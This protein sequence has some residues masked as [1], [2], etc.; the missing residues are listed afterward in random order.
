MNF[1]RNVKRLKQEKGLRND[2]FAALTGI[3]KGTLD[4]L[5]SGAITEPKLSTAI[6]MAEALS[7][8]LDEL[9]DFSAGSECL[10]REEA[11]LLESFRS[12]DRYGR[13][14]VLSLCRREAERTRSENEFSL[15]TEKGTQGDA[16]GKILLPLF[17]LPVSAG[18][19]TI[20]DGD[21]SET[22][23]VRNTR[24]S[25]RADFALRVTGNSMEPKFHNADLLLVEKATSVAPGE[26]GIFIGDGE[27]YFKCFMGDRLHSLNPQYKD[28]PLKNFQDFRCCGR[29]IGR[30]KASEF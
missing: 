14:T 16:N 30:V 15:D 13:E 20:L 3:P 24:I 6:A 19:G 18:T 17:L 11:A 29:V 8:S 10:S 26:L 4:K 25:A 22:V 2:R 27:G 28:I 23:E 12:T 7:V 21:E 5:L 9:C 1:I